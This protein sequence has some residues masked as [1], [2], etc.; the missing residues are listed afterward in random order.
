M[1]NGCNGF[2]STGIW[3]LNPEIFPDYMYEP[4]ETTNI[5]LEDTS[6]LQCSRQKATNPVPIAGPSTQQHLDDLIA[7]SVTNDHQICEITKTL[8]PQTFR[9]VTPD[10]N[11]TIQTIESTE[12]ANNSTAITDQDLNLP[13]PN[14]NRP[15]VYQQRGYYQK[16]R[17]PS[18]TLA[19]SIENISPVPIGQYISGQGKRK[20]KKRETYLILTSTPNMNEI[21]S[22]NEP[23]APSEKRRRNVTTILEDDS[24]EENWPNNAQEDEE[25]CACIYC[26]DLF[27]RSKPGE[28]W[29]RCLICLHWAHASCADVPKRTKRFICELCC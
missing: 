8:H 9:A 13:A 19:A 25:D 24:D 10:N 17:L 15:S 27:S 14:Q 16:Q 5:P 12:Q 2:K 22:R 11:G 6:N 23:K 26:N 1:Q 28:D 20:P 3:P 18:C 29:L 7:L 21:K 4:A